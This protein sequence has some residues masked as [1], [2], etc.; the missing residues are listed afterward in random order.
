[1]TGDPYMAPPPARPF[2]A[3][4]G[5]SPEP[6]RIGLMTRRRR[7]D[8]PLHPE[9]VAAVETR[10]SSSS[11]SAT[12]WSSRPPGAYDEQ[13]FWDHLRLMI[14]VHAAALMDL[15]AAGFG[16]EIRADDVEPYDL[17]S[18]WRMGGKVAGPSLR[19]LGGL[20]AGLG[21]PHGGLVG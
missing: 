6:L 18:S 4:V 3:E 9:C 13:G 14:D 8:R 21:A 10:G 7:S 17:A 16:R 15:F 5:R 1:M 20:A 11:R 2:R 12:R 19:G